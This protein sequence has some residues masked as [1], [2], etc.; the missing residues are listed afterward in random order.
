MYTIINNFRNS[1]GMNFESFDDG[2]FNNVDQ[3]LVRFFQT[4]YGREWKV[5]LD[6]HLYKIKEDKKAA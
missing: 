5:A 6:H 2:R 1:F 4:E 3:N